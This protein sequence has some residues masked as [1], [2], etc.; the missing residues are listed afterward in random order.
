VASE[1]SERAANEKHTPP[2]L[3][4]MTTPIPRS[5]IPGPYNCSRVSCWDPAPAV[6]D[7]LLP[8]APAVSYS[9]RAVLLWLL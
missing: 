1:M 9:S 4:M 3:G 7:I 8:N 2:M 6:V 5:F